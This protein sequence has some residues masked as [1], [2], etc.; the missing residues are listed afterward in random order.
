MLGLGVGLRPYIVPI[1][2]SLCFDLFI[3]GVYSGLLG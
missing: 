2:V 1:P 3:S